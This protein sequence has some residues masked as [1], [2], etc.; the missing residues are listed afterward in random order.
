MQ[1]QTF[2]SQKSTPR[3]MRMLRAR[4]TYLCVLK[5]Y[6][7]KLKFQNS[8]QWHSNTISFTECSVKKPHKKIIFS[9][10]PHL[11]KTKFT[12]FLDECRCDDPFLSPLPRESDRDRDDSPPRPSRRELRDDRLPRRRRPPPPP[13]S[14]RDR[15]DFFELDEFLLDEDFEPVVVERGSTFLFNPPPPIDLLFNSLFRSPNSFCSLVNL[16]SLGDTLTKKEKKQN[17]T[18]INKERKN[19]NSKRKNYSSPHPSAPKKN[20]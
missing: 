10:P 2:Y 13:P 8:I 16:E 12:F 18:K 14:D 20:P 19:F 17:K 3:H 11:P 5:T 15:E 1:L 6:H 7:T 9:P 4:K